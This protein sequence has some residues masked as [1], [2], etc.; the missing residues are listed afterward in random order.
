MPW[1]FCVQPKESLAYALNF[2][3]VPNLDA[4]HIGV[5][6]GTHP[7]KL[8]TAINGVVRELKKVRE[9]GLTEEEVERAK[10]YLIGNFEIGL[11]TNEAQANQISLDVLYGLGS[12]HYRRY[13]QE[14]EKVSRE[15]VHR[16][17][18]EYLNLNAYAIAIIRPPVEKKE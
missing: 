14:I 1:K 13:P 9:E 10:K 18:K 2:F 3:A 6:M 12:D 5:Y 15:D 16:V 8:E 11:Q 7:S 4:G 17:A